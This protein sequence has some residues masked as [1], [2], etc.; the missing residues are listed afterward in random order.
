[1]CEYLEMVQQGYAGV[2]GGVHICIW[3]AFAAESWMPDC[4]PSC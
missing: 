1:V 3:M 4:I 2:R